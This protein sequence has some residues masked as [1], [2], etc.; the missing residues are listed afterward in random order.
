M[1]PTLPDVP[2]VPELPLVP[3]VPLPLVPEEPPPTEIVAVPAMADVPKEI[4]R[5]FALR[6]TTDSGDT[7]ASLDQTEITGSL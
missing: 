4:K 6:G 2:C 5:E 7:R 1:L 3:E